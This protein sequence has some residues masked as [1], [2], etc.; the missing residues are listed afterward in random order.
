MKLSRNAI[1]LLAAA[2]VVLGTAGCVAAPTEHTAADPGS[3]PVSTPSATTAPHPAFVDPVKGAPVVERK[4]APP[5]AERAVAKKASLASAATWSDGVT[6]KAS[7]F[8]RGTVSGTGAGIIKSD[9]V[10]FTLT[11][12]NHSSKKLNLTSVVVTML[13]GAHQQAVAPVYDSVKVHDFDSDVAPGKTATARY[14]FALP[15]KTS[16]A[17]VY[18]DTDGSRLAAELTGAIPQ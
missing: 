2:A 9:Y 12:D 11:I 5:V 10:V 14:A 4:G 6:I 8:S 17:T 15:K 7:Q 16:S 13:A 3:T 18:V 1:V